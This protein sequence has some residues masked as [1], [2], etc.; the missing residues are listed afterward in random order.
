MKNIHVDMTK[1]KVAIVTIDYQGSKVNKVS[2][3]LLDEIA[4][5]LSTMKMDDIIGLVIVSG[6]EDNFVVG[7]DVDEVVAMKNDHEIRAYISKAH[8]IINL[9]DDLPVPVVCC[10]HGNCLGGGL[11]LALASDYR[12]AADSTSTVMGLPEV[13]LGLLPAGG[14]TQRLPRLIGLRQALPL[15]LAGKNVRVR[16]ARKLGLIDEI[17]VPY[18]LRDIGAQKVRELSKKG[19]R[20]KRKRSI[21]DA[22]LESFL[23][24]GIVFKQA[25]QMVMRQTRGLYPAPLEIIDSV[26]FGYKKGMK[27]GLEKDIDRFVKLVMSPE[28]KSLMR[29]FFGITELKKN[30]YKSK[31]RDVKKLAVIGTGL[32]GSGIASVSA[33]LCD[34]ILMKDMS[35]DAAARGMKDVWKGIARQVKSGA[36]RKFDGD[37]MYGKL[38]PCDDYSRFRGTEVVIEAVFEDI[39][40][41]RKIVKDVEEAT[42]DRTIVASNTSALPITSIAKGSRRPQNVI[43][44]H[45]F[46]PV[47][48]MPLLEI[49]TTGKT[50][51]WVTAT[52]LELG[53]RQG[54]TCIIVKDG[55]GFY[56]TRILAPL[57]LESSWVVAE[58]G[59]FPDVDRAMQQFGYPV[60]PMTLLDEVG[61]D[62]G[63]HVIEEV[64]PIFEQRGIIAP[65][66]FSVLAEKGILG[67]KSKKGLY[68]YDVPKR[69]GKK[70]VNTEVYSLFGD[71]PRAPINVEETQHR[72]S[73]MM[74]NE[75]VT[76]LEEG[77]IS[78][79]RDGDMGAI[80]GLGF[81]PFR[82]GPFRYVDGV[83]AAEIVRIMESLTQKFGK[84]FMPARMLRDMAEKGKKFYK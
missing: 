45:Y 76:C 47:P 41:K 27:K 15:M 58:G 21:V 30:P 48:R 38:V 1:D 67:R 73:L 7:A 14:G 36:I 13:M 26:E 68:R 82:G 54:K 42:D 70:P 69:K 66:N 65:M 61:I 40:L 23:G 9:I 3:A 43:G 78:S 59:E 32:M 56:T 37:T 8:R 44:M 84:R 51:P 50:A 33:S 52:A 6:K 18:G 46:S 10:I 57:L 63:I 71:K 24:R 19:F 20:R 80:L 77:I 72:I 79:P 64:R 16:K 62:V 17:V 49:I 35:V 12:I 11:E 34:T 2:S 25:R 31:A 5:F 55:P 22:F 60:G 83:G 39:N 4:G 81:P 28:A 75:A 74:V 29:L 53:I